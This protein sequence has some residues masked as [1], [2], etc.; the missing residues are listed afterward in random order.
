MKFLKFFNSYR[1]ATKLEYRDAADLMPP[2][3]PKKHKKPFKLGLN[4]K[5]YIFEAKPLN[6]SDFKLFDLYFGS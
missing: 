4:I 6:F 1:D 2:N 3:L 5:T